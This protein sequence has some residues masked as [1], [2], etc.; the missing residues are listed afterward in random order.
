MGRV[1]PLLVLVPE[2]PRAGDHPRVR[3]GVGLEP[4]EDVLF[5]L[6]LAVLPRGVHDLLGAVVRGEQQVPLHP[7][8][9]AEVLAVFEDLLD[10]GVGEV[11]EEEQPARRAVTGVHADLQGEGGLVAFAGT[12]ALERG[13]D[14]RFERL[15]Q[16]VAVDH[17]DRLAGE[18]EVL[19]GQLAVGVL[20][21]V[22]VVADEPYPVAAGGLLTVL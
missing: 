17:R 7:V 8:G 18:G 10:R 22:V 6:L 2:G 4:V 20:V 1:V 3:A 12:V 19:V 16:V 5:A 11:S 13:V 9:V 21:A 15:R 14:E